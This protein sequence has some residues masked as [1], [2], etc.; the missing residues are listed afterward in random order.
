MKNPRACDIID[1]GLI[2]ERQVA[3]I[4]VCW[5]LSFKLLRRQ[6]TSVSHT[7]TNCLPWLGVILLL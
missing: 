4:S 7:E 2:Q 5:S 6:G 1:P 3:L